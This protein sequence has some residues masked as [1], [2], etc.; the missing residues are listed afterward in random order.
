LPFE[1][2]SA[3]GLPLPPAFELSAACVSGDGALP[4]WPPLPFPFPRPGFVSLSGGGVGCAGGGG[5]VFLALPFGG[6]GG[7]GDGVTGFS[8]GAVF[9][10]ERPGD[11]AG[12]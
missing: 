5:L 3:S 12:A 11:E 1:P 8:F 4:A 2:V 9:A 10:S 6:V 7:C